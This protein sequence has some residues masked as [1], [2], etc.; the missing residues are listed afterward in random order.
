MESPFARVEP[1]RLASSA[2]RRMTSIA[3]NELSTISIARPG[4]AAIFARASIA[5]LAADAI[6]LKA[7]AARWWAQ[8]MSEF[9]DRSARSQPIAGSDHR[10]DRGRTSGSEADA[11]RTIPPGNRAVRGPRPAG[12]WAPPDRQ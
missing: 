10:R 8:L 1:T 12:G 7:A 3:V 6:S 11:A 9:I 5:I 2:G 4:S